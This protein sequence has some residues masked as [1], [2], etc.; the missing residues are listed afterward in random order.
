[1]ETG[2]T[3]GPPCRVFSA[4]VS[5]GG[6]PKGTQWCKTYNMLSFHPKQGSHELAMV[7]PGHTHIQSLTSWGHSQGPTPGLGGDPLRTQSWHKYYFKLKTL[8][9]QQMQK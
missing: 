4:R 9:I 6:L 3:A 2:F 1:M 7:L 8:E 5:G